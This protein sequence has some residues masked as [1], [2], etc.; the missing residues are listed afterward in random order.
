MNLPNSINN[1]YD[2][3]TELYF[4]VWNMIKPVNFI[5]VNFRERTVRCGSWGIFDDPKKAA[6]EFDSNKG[7]EFV[8]LISY[9][10]NGRPV[11]SFDEQ[12]FNVPGSC[13]EAAAADLLHFLETLESI[14]FLNWRP[15]YPSLREGLC[16]RIDTYMEDGQKHYSGQSRF[17]SQWA[18][19]GK[20]LNELVESV[21]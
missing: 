13:S 14:D 4:A 12:Q 6:E 1:E 3:I 18:A 16:W 11:L 20:A 8:E 15:L 5:W 10:N 19:F 17:P 9:D 21:Q 2:K 7:E